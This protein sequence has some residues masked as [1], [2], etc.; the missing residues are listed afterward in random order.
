MA[1]QVRTR[2]TR[3][4]RGFTL[5]EL[6]V[7]VTIIGILAAIA[8]PTFFQHRLSA[9]RAAVHSDLRNIAIEAET[10]FTDAGT[11]D[12]FESDELFTGFAGSGGV[13]VAIEAADTTATGFCVEGTHSGLPAE[14]WSYQNDRTPQL[15]DAA[16]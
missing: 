10:Y 11:Y 15:G 6:L 16:C 3:C 13:G 1:H 2:E 5:I 4:D 7:V 8:L 14:V 12:G 9:N